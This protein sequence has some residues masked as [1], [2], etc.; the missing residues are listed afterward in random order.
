MENNKS[1]N[2]WKVTLYL[3]AYLV[4][5]ATALSYS[6]VPDTI[7]N[8]DRMDKTIIEQHTTVYDTIKGDTTSDLSNQ[9]NTAPT[10]TVPAST[11]DNTQP[12]LK[13]PPP[14]NRV[15]FGIR[16]MPLFTSLNLHTD[17]GSTASGNVTLSHGAGIALGINFSKNVGIQGEL[18]YYQTSQTINDYSNNQN[19][20]VGMGYVNV[21]LLLSINT[22]KRRAVNLNLVAGPQLGFN[23]NSSVKTTSYGEGANV[24]ASVSKGNNDLGLAYGA[25]LE[26][27]LNRPHTFKLDLGYRGFYGLVDVGAKQTYSSSN[28]AAYNIFVKG[29]RQANGAYLGLRFAF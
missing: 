2:I 20:N 5:I 3:T 28:S 24:N 16:Y 9:N 1:K 15:E 12:V 17:N 10:Y 29:S 8:I 26:F 14:L 22:D 27:A 6:Q 7:K 19:Y 18:N 11:Q 25:G 23:V 21:P 13:D 4:L